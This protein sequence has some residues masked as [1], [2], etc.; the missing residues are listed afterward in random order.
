MQTNPQA[1]EAREPKIHLLLRRWVKFCA[2]ALLLAVSSGGGDVQAQ[3]ANPAT[4]NANRGAASKTDQTQGA[5]PAK[6]VRNSG[7]R[8]AA[9]LYLASSKLFVNEQFEEA[10][11]GYEQ[12][13]AL[14]PGT[15]D[16]RLAASVARS[17]AVTALIQAAAKDRL[18]GNEAQARAALAHA[19]E[20]EPNNIQVNQHLFELGDDA[21]LG[22]SRPRYEQDA[23]TAGKAAEL[24]PTAEVHSFHLRAD[25]RQII[26]QVFK[27]YGIDAT[28]DESVHATPARL[29]VD[30]ASFDTA[31][32]VVG[33]VT[34]SFYIPLDAHHAL[35][36][37]DTR[38]NRQQ[39]TSQEF[40][41]VYLPGL[42]ATEL[43]DTVNLAKNVFDAQQAV[44]EPTAG[45]ITLRASQST[46]NAFNATMRELIDGRSQ[47]MLE[48]RLIQLAHIGG[49]N[50]GVQPPQ[51]TTAFNV[52]AQEQSLLNANQSLVQQI[53][54]SGLA[55]PG[56][57]LAILGILL[58]S[59]QISSSLFSNGVALFGGGL[60]QSAL[61]PGAATLNLNL[62]S[63]DSRELDQ[64]QL[65]LGDGEA[66]TIKTGTKYP[67]QTSSFSSLG[68]S[69]PSI[70]GLTG[71]GSSSSLSSLLASYGG[72]V[73]NIP[74]VQYQDL[75][76][77]LKATPKVLRNGEVALTI[78]M[79]IDA[80]AGTSINGNPVLNN[81]AWS[82]V[83]TVK[84]GE[85]VEVVSEMDKSES[86]AVS[87]T[88]GISEIPGLNN[89]TGIETQKNYATL[90]IVITPHVIRGAQAAGH[91]P[92]MRVERGPAR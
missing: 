60:T 3:T 49:R 27:A 83:V 10:M 87:G 56:D 12:A 72:S 4:Q 17:H 13:A 8:R 73:P 91:S 79:K 52:Y 24:A 47:V 25:Q 14:D 45:T 21:L 35:V 53:I 40:E 50:T 33:L 44:A 42:S 65:R 43:A 77:T 66:A 62:N 59:G 63:S 85:A 55:A 11:R 37:R 75:G 71:A 31:A 70:P 34:A 84:Q 81:R 68:A 80:L 6:A 20:L 22:Q 26:Q 54:S 39:F 15:A 30:D 38:D 86:H 69:V 74:Q 90:L 92:M 32:Y 36:V 41:T 82:G 28:M 19:L 89:L 7:R 46:L 76:L 16:Y 1:H 57:T 5:Q 67:I 23:K 48:V 29:D 88:P 58:A 51:S 9:K 61:A 18:R 78:D 2:A 64:M